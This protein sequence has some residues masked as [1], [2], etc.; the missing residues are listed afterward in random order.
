MNSCSSYAAKIWITA[1][2]AGALSFPVALMYES[3]IGIND[4]IFVMS[5]YV[6]AGLASMVCCLL[7]LI[8]F[9]MSIKFLS[10]F[11]FEPQQLKFSIQLISTVLILANF[12]L[13][14]LLIDGT[15]AICSIVFLFIVAFYSFASIISIQF[16]PLPEAMQCKENQTT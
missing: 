11:T 15:E 6:I 14:V 3:G 12:I 13:P 4:L 16:Y 10:N 5:M 2:W 7:T 9:A 8:P 1:A